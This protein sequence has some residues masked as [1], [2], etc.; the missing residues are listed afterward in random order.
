[1]Q[2]RHI[3]IKHFRGIEQLDWT[4]QSPII[5]LIGAGDSTKSTILDAIEFVLSPKWNI[6]F[7][8][9]DFYLENTDNPIEITITVGQL[10]HEL[11]KQ[12]KFGLETRGWSKLDGLHDEPQD[13][14]EPVLSIKL[15]IDKTLEPQWVVINN[16]NPEGLSISS[17]D[18]EKLGAS[19]LGSFIDKHLYWGQGSALSSLTTDRKENA[20]PMITEAHRKARDE[21]KIEDIEVFKLASVQTEKIAK[22]L[23]FKPKQSLRPALDPKAINIGLGA[24]TIHDGDIPLRLTGLG[25]RR[26]I[27]LGIQL[28]CVADG[29]LLLIDEIEHGLEPHR[30]RHLLNYLRKTVDKNPDKAGQV[31]MTSHSSTTIVELSAE[32]LYVVHSI[33]G[34]TTVSNVSHSLQNIVRKVPEAFLGLKAMVCEGKTEIGIL[35][36]IE[37][38]WIGQK[39]RESLAHN[40]VVLI[41]G[42]GSE[43]PKIAFELANLGYKTCLFADGD[44]LD[45]LTPTPDELRIKGIE[46]FHW[47]APNASEQILAHDFSWATLMKM[48]DLGIELKGEH[49]IYES[50]WK[51]IGKDNRPPN[52]DL[53]EWLASGISEDAIRKAIGGAAS[54]NNEKGWF[55]RIDYGEDLGR[56]IIEDSPNL[57]DSETLKV[58]TQIEGWIYG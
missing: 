6:S 44:K 9:C 39:G 52:N 34:E 12:E 13:D 32:N 47:S 58:L 37:E 23:G 48:V 41:L 40:G 3:L 8:D 14:D 5:C 20:A 53:A 28:S 43:S 54:S 29:S 51:K 15:S 30:L 24:V 27:T 38:Y 7:E 36:A 2:I 16:R 11:I 55:K 19:R 22:E 18:R 45:Q 33:N 42:G 46:V 49:N 10:P 35:R 57:A 1:M 21:A 31:I 50:I 25:S 17:K 26:L 4:I 56:L